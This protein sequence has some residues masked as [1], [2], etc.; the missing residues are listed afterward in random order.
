MALIR[1]FNEPAGLEYLSDQGVDKKTI[2]RL[3]LL[4]ISGIANLLGAVKLA[5]YM[6]MGSDDVVVTVATD[7]MDLYRSRLEEME[8]ERGAFT[9][10]D[11]AAAWHRHLLGAGIDHTHELS[12]YDRKRI[13]NLKYFTWVEQQ[14]Q[15]ADELTAQWHDPDYWTS[16]QGQGPEID[17]LIEEFNAAVA[18]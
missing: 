14:G 6:E 2:D 3:E 12:Y 17:R 13:H 16:I 11:A 15:S 18:S 9:D 5:K 7:S 8:A 10:L 1:L 4:G